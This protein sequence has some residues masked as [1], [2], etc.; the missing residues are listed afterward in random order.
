MFPEFFDGYIKGIPDA[1]VAHFPSQNIGH[2]SWLYT[3]PCGF[4]AALLADP[5]VL[6]SMD[7]LDSVSLSL[8]MTDFLPLKSRIFQ[9]IYLHF[10]AN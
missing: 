7:R 9:L 4:G 2:F 10:F 5:L 8:A 1:D 3:A 6:I